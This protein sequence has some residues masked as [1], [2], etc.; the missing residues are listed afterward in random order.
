MKPWDLGRAIS[1]RGGQ[2]PYDAALVER[3]REQGI[4]DVEIYERWD[5]I[6]GITEVQLPTLRTRRWRDKAQRLD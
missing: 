3:L 6:D 4:A 1:A 5:E 2:R